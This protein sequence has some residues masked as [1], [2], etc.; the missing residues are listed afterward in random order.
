MK[1]NINTKNNLYRKEHF[2]QYHLSSQNIFRD[3]SKQVQDWMIE[4]YKMLS[5]KSKKKRQILDRELEI[6]IR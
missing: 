2:V 1:N 3:K 4:I 5:I 6:S